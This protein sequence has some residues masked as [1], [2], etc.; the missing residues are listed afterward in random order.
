MYLSSDQLQQ[1]CG[2]LICNDSSKFVYY[3][4]KCRSEFYSGTELE[5]HIVFDHQDRKKHVDGIFID[6]G[7]DLETTTTLSALP[8]ASLVKT[9][10]IPNP[11]VDTADILP[12]D[13]VIDSTTETTDTVEIGDEI[14]Q[15]QQQSPPKSID[16]LEK[17]VP[18]EKPIEAIPVD[19]PI[20]SDR[21]D[22]ND[23]DKSSDA[24]PV[25]HEKRKKGSFYCDLC[26]GQ[27]FRTL[28]VIKAHIKR[29]VANKLQ[30]RQLCPFCKVRPRNYEKHMR[31]AHT[32]AK[33]Y[34]CVFCDAS[35]K[36]N[37]ARVSTLPV[38][39]G[40]RIQTFNSS[41]VSQM[42]IHLHSSFRCFPFHAQVIHTR[43]H[44]G[45]R[46]YLCALCGKSFKSEDSRRKHNTRMHSEQ[47]PHPCTE[48]DRRFIS[49]SQLQEHIYSTHSTERPYTCEVCGRSY[50]TRKY[51]RK[52][53][54]SHGERIHL[55][56]HCGKK[57]K[58]T[59]TRR[60]HLRKV[61]KILCK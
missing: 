33:P 39:H 19:E 8:F 13:E 55:C 4:T 61:H 46:P 22:S 58:T 53:L 25:E 50:S 52:H 1:I 12:S 11:I 26:P 43:T 3:C 38:S 23:C 34:K 15:Q 48:C 51:L 18:Y 36:N 7:I 17:E 2:I 21:S 20:Q 24:T 57:F 35:F 30:S 29:H 45:E 49:P 16:Q 9:E 5:D 54:Q 44:T 32:E 59:E 40:I 41:E 42:P 10:V 37:M 14:N 27:S 6:D 60:W 56:N 28:D 31:Y 47:L